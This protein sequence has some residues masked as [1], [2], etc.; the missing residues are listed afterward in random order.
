MAYVFAVERS[1]AY[2][3]PAY[4]YQRAPYLFYNVS[5]ARN[6]ALRDPITPEKG[7]ARILRRVARNALDLPMALGETLTASRRYYSMWLHGLLG[8]GPV[9]RPVIRWGTYLWLSLLGGLLT[10]GGVVILLWRGESL[11]PLYVLAYL[12]ALALTP[13]PEQYMRYLMPIAPLAALCAIVLL[14]HVGRAGTPLSSPRARALP[15]T[16]L[17][18]ALLVQVAV[19][20]IV[21]TRE[22]QRVAY[23]DAHGQPLSHRLF[24]YDD[25]QR[26]FDEAVDYLESHAD[27]SQVIAAG[28]PHWIHLRTGLSAVMPPFEADPSRAAALLD[29]VPVDYLIIGRDV[30]GTERY[31]RPVVEQRPE[32]W[33]RV[34]E[35]KT[36][37]WEVFRRTARGVGLMK[38]Q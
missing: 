35:T 22:H 20:V 4:E 19:T 12:A 24:F 37:G 9:L 31:T 7:D 16:V 11:V 13:F 18:P 17:V 10:A 21:F 32:A 25:S 5:Y 27:S 34:Y 36:G 28:T 38:P 6:I 3:N 15:F 1:P 29:G 2:T 26:G 8:D 23:R 33:Q 30:V 14:V